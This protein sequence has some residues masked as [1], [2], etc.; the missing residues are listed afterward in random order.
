MSRPDPRALVSQIQRLT[1]DAPDDCPDGQ[2]LERFRTRSDQ[3]AFAALVRRH[4]PLVW[5]VC[6]RVLGDRHDAEDAFQAAFLVLAKKADSIRRAESLGAWLHSVA[7]QLALRARRGR[8]RRHEAEAGRGA[9]GAAPAAAGEPGEELSLR[10]A[11]AI[12][13]E[14]IGRLPEKFRGPVVLCYL[15]GQTNEDAARELGC[16][17]GTLK[18][19]LGRARDLLGE[20]LTRRGVILPAGAAALLLTTGAS[21]ELQA[22][23]G[24]RVLCSPKPLARRRGLR[25][26]RN[27]LRGWR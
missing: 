6:R 23:R 8:A 22:A 9:G 10:E 20:R 25:L 7:R 16:P 24:R 27:S 12:L 1:G 5:G 13:D 21:R 14:E 15:Q 26:R 2:L 17:V 3:A 11:L 18:T 4:G 19:R